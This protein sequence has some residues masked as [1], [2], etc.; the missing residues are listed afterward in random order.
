VNEERTGKCLRQVE[1]IRGHLWHRYSITVNQVMV[2]TVTFSKWWL[3]LYQKEPLVQKH[4]FQL[5]PIFVLILLG[6]PYWT[7]F[8]HSDLWK[9]KIH[10]NKSLNIVIKFANFTINNISTYIQISVIKHIFPAMFSGITI[11]IGYTLNSTRKLPHIKKGYT[12]INLLQN[13]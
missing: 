6:T 7:T 9:K 3:Q 10:M 5:F 1:H 2:A 12:Y 4:I 11:N 13:H 8:L